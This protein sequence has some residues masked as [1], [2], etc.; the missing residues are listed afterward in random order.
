M[1]FW[2]EQSTPR[3]LSDSKRYCLSCLLIAFLSL[4]FLLPQ[5]HLR[6]ASLS[7]D[8]Q[9]VELVPVPGGTG[10]QPTRGTNEIVDVAA[11]QPCEFEELIPSNHPTPCSDSYPQGYLLLREHLVY[12]QITASLL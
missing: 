6:S 3:Y 7:D 11:K 9:L 8:C 12:T 2:C 10:L 1:N 5:A 4:L